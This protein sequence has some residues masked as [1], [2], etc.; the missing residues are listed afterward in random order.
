MGSI[1]HFKQFQVDQT[2]C[3]MKINT[4]G[5]LLAALADH[6]APSTILDIGSGTGVIAIM[7]AQRFSDAYIDAVEIDAAAA[8]RAAHNAVNSPF[9]S[10]LEVFHSDINDFNPNRY[11][12]LIVSN[13][14]YFVNDLKSVEERKGMARHADEYFFTNLLSKSASL[15]TKDGCF[16]L[17]LPLK[18]AAWIITNAVLYNLFPSH[19]YRVH[20]DKDKP[21]IRQI[22]CLSAKQ[23]AIKSEQFFI[24][25][26]QQVYTKEYKSLLKDFFLNF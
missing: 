14:P 22:I 4:D 11:Y 13:P 12:D 26:Y 7:M 6:P 1:F 8:D 17:I 15:L 3:A 10:R 16:W 18:Q 25:E 20:S 21:E 9:S 24:Y 23:T 5:V 2:G 19:I